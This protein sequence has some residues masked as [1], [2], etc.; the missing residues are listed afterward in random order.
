MAMK[1][2]LSILRPAY[3]AASWIEYV[4]VGWPIPLE[5]TVS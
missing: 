3:S 4:M 5:K 2:L 1:P